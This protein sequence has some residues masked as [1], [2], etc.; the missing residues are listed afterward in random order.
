MENDSA[1]AAKKIRIKQVTDILH[2]YSIP[3]EKWTGKKSTKTLDDLY[4]EVESKESTLTVTSAGKLL[5]TVNIA[6]AIVISTHPKTGKIFKLIE[7][8]Q[9]FADGSIRKRE[10]LIGGMTEKIKMGES[11]LEGTVRGLRE[12]LQIINGFKLATHVE[13]IIR[14]AKTTSYPGLNSK[15]IIQKTY[16]KLDS[17][18]LTRTIDSGFKEL[19]KTKGGKLLKTTY[20]KWV[21]VPK[22]EQESIL[23]AFDDVIKY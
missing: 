22:E 16:V 20:F 5:R 4:E 13:N 23:A 7:T 9:V 14:N 21:E 11:A 8:R 17:E 2:S 19:Q 6:S 12:E 3:I 10:H 1:K 15:Q 18:H